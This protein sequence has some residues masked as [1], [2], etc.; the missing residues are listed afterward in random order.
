[1]YAIRSLAAG[2]KK[3]LRESRRDSFPD[4][5]LNIHGAKLHIVSNLAETIDA[6]RDGYHFFE[7]EPPEQDGRVEHLFS[8]SSAAP[9]YAALAA[10]LFP[11]GSVPPHVLVP[12]SFDRV[13]CVSSSEKL[14][15]LTGSLFMALVESLLFDDYLIVHGAAIARE[16][17]LMLPGALRCGKTTLALSLLQNGFR[18]ASDDVV[19]VHRT[20]MEVHPFPRLL[21]LRAESLVSVPGLHREY[22]EMSVSMFFGEPRWF[23]DKTDSVAE[24]FSCRYVVFPSFGSTTRLD[25]ITGADAGL[26]LLSHCFLPI[27]PLRRFTSTA[28][29]LPSIAA[30]LA[31]A[32]SYRLVQRDANEGVRALSELVA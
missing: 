30:L 26:E 28:E 24:P 18:L 5:W 25:P 22:P 27:T 31:D 12:L 17:G 7:T 13:Y 15:Y 32:E 20:K 1:V 8:F 16:E 9:G 29:N 23:L 19:L 11:S 14:H 6:L 3:F 2:Q 4:I 10:S 21:N